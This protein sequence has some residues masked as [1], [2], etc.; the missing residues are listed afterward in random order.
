[1]TSQNQTWHNISGEEAISLLKVNYDS[2]LTASVAAERL[3]SY[4]PNELYGASSLSWFQVLVSNFLNPMNFIL[5]GGMV[6]TAI[7]R[8]WPDMGV[9]AIVIITNTLI[10]FK[11]EYGSEKTMEALKKMSSPVAKVKRDGLS[12]SF[13]AR[14]LCQV[15]LK[16]S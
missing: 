10:G 16:N 1:M 6:L 4:G 3:I 14:M 8:D 9:L 15:N 11:Q 2:G 7:F 12:I 13:P 5:F